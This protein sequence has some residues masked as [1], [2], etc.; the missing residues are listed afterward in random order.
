[1]RRVVSLGVVLS[2]AVCAAF[3]TQAT[4]EAAG[5]GVVRIVYFYADDCLHCIT[6]AEEVLEALQADYGDGLQ[7][8][9]VEV[10][11][12]KNYELLVR[13][14]ELFGVTPEER[15]IPTLV[16]DGT[17]LIGEEAVRDR[18]P[19]ILQECSA[20]GGTSW[21]ALP[22][23]DAIEYSAG[24]GSGLSAVPG[25]SDLIEPCGEEEVGACEGP[26][27]IWVAY[28]YEVGCQQ[29]SR[30]EYDIRYARS[31]Y[32][33][34]V[35]DEYNAQDDAP[36]LQWLGERYALPDDLHLTT[37]AVF[38]G[39]EALIG[40]EITSQRL[41]SLAEEYV[42]TGSGRVWDEFGS[43]ETEAAVE[44]IVGRFESFGVLTVVLAGLVDG[45]NPCAFATLVFFVSYLTLSGR[46]G[47]EVL[48][49]GGAFTIG[50]FLTYLA[51]GLGFYKVL[52]L[53]GSALVLVGRWVYVL[54]GVLCAG[55]AVYSF[56]DFLK[57]RRGDIGDMALNLPERLRLRINA[58][59]RKGR[60]TQAYVAGAFATGAVV[61]VLELACTGQVYLPTI[62]FVMSQPALRVR[63]LSYLVVYNLLFTLPLAVVFLLAYYGTESKQFSRFLQERAASVKL[64]LA[65]LFAALASWMLFT[66]AV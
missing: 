33:Q 41:L 1:M 40:S 29:C 63:A 45:L 22:G 13:A 47:R 21:P 58:V 8:K 38:L 34:I 52:D 36:L 20:A 55:L 54:T 5:G 49:V 3:L 24:V 16:V 43:Q 37:P 31:S 48:Y 42:A 17:V 9:M 44:S 10:S 39:D 2:I 28:F 4:V 50:V 51:V 53:L 12:P 25:G 27:P 66:L 61:S 11:E 15:A 30:A 64:A 46:E 19:C 59:I 6:V 60:H 14:E 7:I 32:P 23:L 56:L 62:V 18:L 35:V 26:S 65:L 57:A